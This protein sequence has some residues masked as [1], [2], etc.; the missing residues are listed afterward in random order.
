MEDS[1]QPQTPTKMTHLVIYD[2]NC[3]LCVTLVQLLEHLDRGRLFQYAPMQAEAVL[4]GY[5]ITPQGCEL[6]MILL[7]PQQPEQRWQGSDA[8]EEIGRML[9][10]GEMFVAAYRMLPGMKWMGDRLYD[11]VRDRRYT[12]FGRRAA[13]Y[14]SIYPARLP[15]EVE[16]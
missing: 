9:P 16:R 7:N 15:S 4:S 8:A 11:R 14:W 10:L 1:R 13:T 3:N 5:E 2:G 12:L 6:G